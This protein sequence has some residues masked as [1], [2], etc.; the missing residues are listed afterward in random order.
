MAHSLTVLGI[1]TART[2]WGLYKMMFSAP[3]M[4]LLW[5]AAAS[6]IGRVLADSREQSLP[7]YHYGAPIG[8]ECMNRSS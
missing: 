7:S 8:V 3:K 2:P 5:L 6:S 1:Q 4:Q